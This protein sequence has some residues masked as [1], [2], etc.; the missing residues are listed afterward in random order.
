MNELQLLQ[1]TLEE[2]AY[3]AGRA[4]TVEDRRK[5]D[6]LLRATSTEVD[7]GSSPNSSG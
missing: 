5:V 2:L 1:L 6:E 3:L 7:E 4:E